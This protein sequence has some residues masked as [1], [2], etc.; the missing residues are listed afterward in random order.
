MKPITLGDA[1]LLR[2]LFLTE[3]SVYKSRFSN[4][5]KKLLSELEQCGVI[6]IRH[7]AA[8]SWQVFPLSYD[9]FLAH[10]R[11]NYDIDDLNNYIV[12][13][14]LESPGRDEL[15]ALGISTKLRNIGPKTG[16]HINSPFPLEVII[17]GQ[18]V[19]PALPV[20]TALFVHEN[21]EIQIP[22]NVVIVGVENFTNI[23]NAFRQSHLFEQSGRVLFVERCGTLQALL[24]KVSNRYIHYG[25]IDL[26]GIHIYQ[27][28]YAS[29]V[30]E[31]GSF[32][33]PC[34]INELFVR[35]KGLSELFEQQKYKYVSLEG[36]DESMQ[37]L[38]D[39]IRAMKKG[40]EQEA[41]ISN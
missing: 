21:V 29:L 10:I 34:A 9:G 19:N 16:I 32:F 40:I 15:S 5:A 18:K 22:E 41:F 12:A 2:D 30:G 31:R 23:T 28:Q 39:E 11:T 24:A 25:D 3:Q 33:L 8:R 38:I 26:A 36:I 14:E 37:M 27:T 17:A 1:R 35:F 4:G 6:R 13:L 7:V 20:G